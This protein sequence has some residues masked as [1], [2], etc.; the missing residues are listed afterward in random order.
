MQD[1][2]NTSI[3]HIGTAHKYDSPFILSCDFLFE[4]A[5]P[6]LNCFFLVSF[7]ESDYNYENGRFITKYE[8]KDALSVLPELIK[9]H[10]IIIF[11]GL[12][13]FNAKLALD[14][15]DYD[16]YL[17]IFWGAEVY[18]N[19]LLNKEVIF[20]E[21][22]KKIALTNKEISLKKLK[23]I[24]RKY[25]LPPPQ[26][27]WVKNAAALIKHVG[28]TYQED[29]D[30]LKSKQVLNPLSKPLLFSYFPPEFVFR[31]TVEG[32]Y[33][34]ENILIGNSATPENNHLEIFK[35][36]KSFH[37]ESRKL[38]TILSYGD[39]AYGNKIIR[40]GI[41]KFPN[42]FTAITE[43]LP[44][45]QYNEILQ[46]CS[47][48]IMNHYRQ[49]GIGNIYSLL[50][51]GTKVFLNERNTMYHYLKRIGC[52]VYSVDEINEKNIEEILRPLS[53]IEAN[54]NKRILKEE[55]STDR[56]VR[57]LHKYFEEN[58]QLAVQHAR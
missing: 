23:Q 1:N 26:F 5:F 29:F 13:G 32:Q 44:L 22:T 19:T 18:N 35:K 49:Q 9:N 36:L 2:H 41:K 40:E 45:N 16:K 8:E 25:I 7:D 57:N 15:G 27:K 58:F 51:M 21:S 24:I 55:L 38:I 42:E 17:W 46:T 52:F 3:L 54:H 48:A 37:S 10:K 47:V 11:H 20:G 56:L 14:V 6:G 53:V 12:S 33:K 43:F 4:K 34:G 39:D 30:N 50:W 28:V 31:N